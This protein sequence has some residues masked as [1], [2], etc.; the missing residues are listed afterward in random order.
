MTCG[1]RRI[2]N[3]WS[4]R[5]RRQR[6]LLAHYSASPSLG[7]R[8]KPSAATGPDGPADRQAIGVRACWQARPAAP[9]ASA[10]KVSGVAGQ[11]DVRGR[12]LSSI[13]VFERPLKTPLPS[14]IVHQHP[15][16][17]VS[18]KVSFAG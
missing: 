12:P 2:R 9:T 16:T 17:K 1:W 10:A 13:I 5:H 7:Q 15:R 14:G 6:C 8:P 4:L 3:R 18:G 11:T